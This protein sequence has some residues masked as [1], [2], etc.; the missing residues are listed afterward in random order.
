MIEI[1]R[2]M[3]GLCGENHPSIL[4]LLGVTPFVNHIKILWYQFTSYVKNV[5]KRHR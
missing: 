2:H 5:L 3:F 4:Y 1:I